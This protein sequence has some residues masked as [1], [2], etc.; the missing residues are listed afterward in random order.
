MGTPSWA[1]DHRKMD[2]V[3]EEAGVPDTDKCQH[4]VEEITEALA[5]NGLS[6]LTKEGN[7]FVMNASS[8][9]KEY[10]LRKNT[11][12]KE[13]CKLLQKDDNLCKVAEDIADLNSNTVWIKFYKAVSGHHSP[14]CLQLVNGAVIN[15]IEHY[16]Q[17]VRQRKARL[18]TL[19]Y[20]PVSYSPS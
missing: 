11:V 9:T 18:F 20:S 13:F 14:A 3:L 7:D 17:V 2:K 5:Q 19:T 4:T 8:V 6:A 16:G 10:S 15:Y 12:I 1:V